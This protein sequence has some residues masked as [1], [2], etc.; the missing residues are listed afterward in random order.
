M[1]QRKGK[2]VLIYFFLFFIVSS[3]NNISLNSLKFKK[4]KD[5]SIIGLEGYNNSILLK[6]IK[7]LDLGI[8]FFINSKKIQN[9]I[10]A[11]TLVEKYDVFK[12]YPSSLDINI[13]KTSFFARINKEG[14]IFLIGS[15]GKLTKNNFSNNHLPFIFGNPNIEDFLNFKKV[16]DQSKFSYDDFKNLYFFSS[17]R[18][19]IE[20]K[21]DL[22]IKLS[23]N[24][25]TD[26]LQLIFEFLEN[27]N[28]R[29]IKI[30]D[31]RIKDQIILND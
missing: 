12:R 20:L 19:D 26:Y 27:N 23:A 25:T 10:D 21:N 11:N 15:N 29:D 6:E 14:K 4:I 8:I 2:K 3:I 22:I 17:K 28:F 13:K 18:W 1:H 5:I 31:A 24:Y 7:N 30:V 16:I 9:Q